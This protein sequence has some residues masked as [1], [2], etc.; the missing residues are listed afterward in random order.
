MQ[1]RQ[2]PLL[3]RAGSRL[4]WKTTRAIAECERGW[5]LT[6][7]SLSRRWRLEIEASTWIAHAYTS[8]FFGD[9]RKGPGTVYSIYLERV[10][11][12]KA[13]P[14]S[15]LI[16][17]LQSRLGEHYGSRDSKSLVRVI[18]GDTHPRVLLA[19]LDH[20]S[21]AFGVDEHHP[22]PPSH[23]RS[24]PARLWTIAEAVIAHATWSLESTS[25]EL[26]NG[27]ELAFASARLT[28]MACSVAG[29][30]GLAHL[31]VFDERAHAADL[32]LRAESHGYHEQTY[33]TDP[34]TSVAKL[35]PLSVRAA[36]KEARFLEAEIAHLRR[37]H[38]KR[39]PRS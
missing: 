32:V 20:I 10:G 23:A 35:Q 17:E 27:D 2:L 24:A 38:R 5:E 6:G 34:D 15:S 11:S 21:H 33:K 29:A 4:A 30:E 7:L 26:F 1:I 25:M 8:F 3:H 14:P 28:S 9:N 39:S 19:E 31:F 13:V 36:M 16:Q 37:T 22:G 12:K 18:R